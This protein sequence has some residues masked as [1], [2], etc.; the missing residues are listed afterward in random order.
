MIG[1]KEITRKYNEMVKTMEKELI[2]LTNRINCYV[3]DKCGYITKT[4]DIDKGVIPFMFTCKKCG[5]LMAKSTFFNDIVPERKPTIEW[6]RPTL[7]EVLK[8]RNKQDGMLEH[9][10]DGGL[11]YRRLSKN[12]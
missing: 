10:L 12:K 2:D 5:N 9:I 7:K 1:Q 8:M 11:D 4:K 6:Y 3:C